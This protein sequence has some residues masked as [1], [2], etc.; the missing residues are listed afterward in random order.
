MLGRHNRPDLPPE[1]PVAAVPDWLPKAE[2]PKPIG[3]EVFYNGRL[4]GRFL[5]TTI[6][7]LEIKTDSTVGVHFLMEMDQ[8]GR[9][10]TDQSTQ[11]R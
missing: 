3:V 1:R 6:N 4:I 5:L 10:R 9:L 11:R 7:A 8:H 2:G